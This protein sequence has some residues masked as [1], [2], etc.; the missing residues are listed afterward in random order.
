MNDSIKK[1]LRLT[2]KDLMINEVTYET[3]Q[4][5]KTLIVNAVLSPAPY[6]CRNVVIQW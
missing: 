5:T 3:F 6:A 4:N 2:D 1:M